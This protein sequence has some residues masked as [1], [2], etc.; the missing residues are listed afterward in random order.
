MGLNEDQLGEGL[1]SV[2]VF[3]LEVNVWVINEVERRM[4]K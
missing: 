2:N 4:S 3:F 1:L